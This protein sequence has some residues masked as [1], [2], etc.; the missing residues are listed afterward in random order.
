MGLLALVA[1]AWLS[2]PLRRSAHFALGQT[3]ASPAPANAIPASFFG[4]HLGVAATS[5][6]NPGPW[7]TP[8]LP[9]L[10]VGAMGKCVASNWPYIERK[11]TEYSWSQID[12]CVAWAAHFGIR[13]FQSWEYMTPASVGAQDPATDSRCWETYVSK[14]FACMGVMTAQGEQQWAAFN[15]AMALRYR[16]SPGMDFYEGWNEP[17]YPPKSGVPAITAA[18]LARYERIRATAIRVNDP[19]AKLASPAFILDPQHPSYAAFLDDFLGSDPPAY[20]Y[21]D[22]HIDYRNQPEDEISSIAQFRQVLARHGIA[23]PTLLATEAGRGGSGSGASTETCP[24]WPSNVSQETQQAFVA[25][26]E[27]IYWS[28]GVAR[29]YWYAYDTCGSLSNQPRSESLTR[30]GVAYA[31]VESWMI[32]ATMSQACAADT[33]SPDL[34]SCTLTR[35]EGYQATVVW[36]TRGATSWITPAG[37]VRYRDL[38][39]NSVAVSEG[40]PIT[41][42]PRPLLVENQ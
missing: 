14:V 17:P 3:V 20:D 16:G 2:G 39:G 23:S 15:A 36:N 28:Q 38:D 35:D 24:G 33:S 6:A 42:G 37:A 4:N 22:F 18:Q 10:V 41:I 29:H 7:G 30:A 12:R 13:Y 34:W 9:P 26:M 31:T 27:L 11:P 40:A 5:L 32:G 1:I 19:D 25:R 8:I 21:Y